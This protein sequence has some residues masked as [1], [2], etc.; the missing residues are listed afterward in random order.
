[1]KKTLSRALALA[2]LLALAVTVPGC[3]SYEG[4][5]D[6]YGYP[7]RGERERIRRLLLP[8]LGQMLFRAGRDAAARSLLTRGPPDGG[9]HPR[10]LRCRT[11][12]NRP[13]SRSVEQICAPFSRESA[14]R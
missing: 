3:S 14:A 4:P 8:G 9:S 1:M 10:G 5:D 2:G 11:P 12:G 6:S 13:K 7:R